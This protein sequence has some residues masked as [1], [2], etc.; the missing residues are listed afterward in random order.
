MSNERIYTTTVPGAEGITIVDPNGIED[1]EL[2]KPRYIK[3]EDLM[4]YVELKALMNPK[5]NVIEKSQDSVKSI[6]ITKG[7]Y[8]NSVQ[9]KEK[10]PNEPSYFT[11]NWTDMFDANK[12]QDVEGFGIQSMDIEFN[13]S[14]VPSIHIEFIDVRGKNLLERGNDPN[15]PYN[16]FYTFPYPLFELT[17]KGYF[18][19]AITMPLVMEK[20]M[21]RFDP[22]TGSYII[23]A[24]FKSWTFAMLNDL[25]IWYALIVPYMYPIKGADGKDSFEGFEIVK[26]KYTELNKML[27][28]K[29]GK[30]KKYNEIKLSGLFHLNEA[31]AKIVKDPLMEAAAQRQPAVGSTLNILEAFRTTTLDISANKE[32]NTPSDN[33][34]ILNTWVQKSNDMLKAQK[35]II[36]DNNKAGLGTE[37]FDIELKTEDYWDGKNQVVI[38]MND[39]V[40]KKYRDDILAFEDQAEVID[41]TTFKEKIIQTIK[42]IPSVENVVFA[43][44]VHMDAFVE[45]LKKK[46][47]DIIDT[48]AE[49][50]NAVTSAAAYMNTVEYVELGMNKFYRMPWPEYYNTDANGI[51]VKDFPGNSGVIE[52]RKWGE[53]DFINEMY[54][55]IDRLNKDLSSGVFGNIPGGDTYVATPLLLNPFRLTTMEKMVGTVNNN[56]NEIINHILEQ[57][58]TTIFHSGI[59]YRPISDSNKLA[60]G[61]PKVAGIYAIMI[62]NMFK[63]IGEELKTTT[64]GTNIAG[65]LGGIMSTISDVQSLRAYAI[66]KKYP[67]LISGDYSFKPMEANATKMPQHYFSVIRDASSGDGFNR[68]KEIYLK[69]NT[70]DA[71]DYKMS[72]SQLRYHPKALEILD[73]FAYNIRTDIG[74]IETAAATFT[75][76]YP[77]ND[78]FITRQY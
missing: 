58:I 34:S 2:I 65:A 78:M 75:N 71:A 3:Q 37:A 25:I 4:I 16:V 55:A 27:Y 8:Y 9:T 60:T 72:P 26:T 29:Y 40:Y 22:S 15:N 52:I 46:S 74:G 43:M 19:K 54:A 38:P 53:V 47:Q 64:N 63:I 67:N 32:Q 42:F 5:N 59:L 68:F 44:V 28:Q 70:V 31:I 12:P 56:E 7:V 57:V 14:L 73:L 23:S 39:Q 66:D 17:V 51:K 11:T 6:I 49:P 35:T 41:A 77:T 50:K 10:T 33:Q 24:D 69:N 45:L 61:D 21:T 20:A 36:I 62:N 1:G 48:I 30:V 18:G 76:N 13:A